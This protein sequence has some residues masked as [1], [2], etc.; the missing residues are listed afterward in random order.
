MLIRLTWARLWRL[1][2][3]DMTKIFYAP[4]I[5]RL[6]RKILW[7]CFLIFVLVCFWHSEVDFVY[8]AF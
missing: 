6:F 5:M 2:R 1:A 4:Q 3:V 8:R 7:M